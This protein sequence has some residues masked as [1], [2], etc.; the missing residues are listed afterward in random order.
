MEH[1]RLSYGL[2]DPKNGCPLLLYPSV[3]KDLPKLVIGESRH[4]LI[5]IG[6]NPVPNI[7]NVRPIKHK[8]AFHLPII[9]N[10]LIQRH[11]P[12]RQIIHP[13]PSVRHLPSPA[14][15]PPPPKKRQNAFDNSKEPIER[16]Q[17]DGVSVWE[18][19]AG[20]TG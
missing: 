15:N 4:Q 17:T 8:R 1:T 10:N 18:D 7:E 11:L 13:F 19:F 2:A 6:Q 9:L 5:G 12:Q 20:G 3:S 14:N 16:D